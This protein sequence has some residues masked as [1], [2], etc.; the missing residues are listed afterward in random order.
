MNLKY[1]ITDHGEVAIGDV[2][3]HKNLIDYVK[4]NAIS[5]G[6][7]EVLNWE[8]ILWGSSN[9]LKVSV[10]KYDVQTLNSC[11]YARSNKKV[12]VAKYN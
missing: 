6:Y 9:S 11:K 10:G 12:I 2:N 7:C 8:W 3:S 5:G 4:G 1:I